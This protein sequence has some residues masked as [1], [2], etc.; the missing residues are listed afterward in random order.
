[1]SHKHNPNEKRTT[2]FTLVELLV[3]IGL[4]AFM[5]GMITYALL[6]AQTD[7]RASRTRGTIQKLNEVILQQWEEYR[8]RS[9]DYRSGSTTFQRKEQRSNHFHVHQ[10]I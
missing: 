2:G 8:Y 9:I 6:G 1:M 5:G 7:A 10:S 3:V 4:I